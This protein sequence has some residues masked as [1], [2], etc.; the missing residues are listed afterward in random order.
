MCKW[1]D[2]WNKEPRPFV[3]TKSAHEILETNAAY[4]Q[5][6]I[7]SGPRGSAGLNCTD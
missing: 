6:I 5:R 3:R 7:D 2:E 1:I 4:C